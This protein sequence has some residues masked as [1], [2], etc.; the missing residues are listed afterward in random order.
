MVVFYYAKIGLDYFLVLSLN[1][2]LYLFQPSYLIKRLSLKLTSNRCNIRVTKLRLSS[3]K[4]GSRAR[5]RA[6]Q[7]DS[8]KF[9][10][11]LGSLFGV[12]DL[13]RLFAE[14]SR[15]PKED[16]TILNYSRL[17]IISKSRF[18]IKVASNSGKTPILFC[19]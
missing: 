17:L 5:P 8:V 10:G 19:Y 15:V 2:L 7:I 9:N 14:V 13:W 6:R 12:P 18:Q 16:W 11:G 3:Q 1:S 4:Y